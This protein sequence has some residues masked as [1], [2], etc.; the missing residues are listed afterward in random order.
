MCNIF[1]ILKYFI[2]NKLLQFLELIQVDQMW[3]FGMT[4]AYILD[5]CSS[6]FL[7]L[8]LYYVGT[9]FVSQGIVFTDCASKYY[10]RNGRP[11]TETCC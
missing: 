2:Y 4:F 7:D 9:C 10:F 5:L 11:E 1:C 3:L 8:L 6:Y